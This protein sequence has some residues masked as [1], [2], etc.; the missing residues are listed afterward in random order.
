MAKE[1]QNFQKYLEENPMELFYPEALKSGTFTIKEMRKQYSYARSVAMKRLKI[2]G[3][4]E[5]SDTQ[6]YLKNKNLFKPLSEIE[7]ESELI[8]RL[9]SVQKFVRSSGST[10]RGQYK[11]REK[12]VQAAQDKGLDFVNEDNI[13]EFGQYMDYL[14]AKYKG[15]QFDSERAY[16]LFVAAKKKDVDPM[17]IADDFEYWKKNV[18]YLKNTRKIRSDKPHSA[19][20]YKAQIERQKEIRKLMNKANAVIR[21]PEA[22]KTKKKK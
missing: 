18:S 21:D 4:S 10:I 3:E 19:A 12:A 5:F 8:K 11:L 13:A 2:L 22:K 20:H 9:Y 17:E 14:R 7:S 6:S 15:A 1:K 16:R